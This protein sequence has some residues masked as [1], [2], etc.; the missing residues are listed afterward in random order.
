MKDDLKEYIR[1]IKDFPK[2][3][4]MF[5]DI[6]TLLK[7]PDALKITLEQFYTLSKDLKITKVEGSVLKI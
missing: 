3:G 4:I 2:A 7:N 1:S 6:T 5:R